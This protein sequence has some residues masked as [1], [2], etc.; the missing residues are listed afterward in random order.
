[1]NRTLILISITFATAGFS[2]ATKVKK[3]QKLVHQYESGQP[4]DFSVP[5]PPVNPFPAQFPEGNKTFVKKVE[6]NL[7]KEALASLSKNLN[8]EIIIKVNGEGDV[9]N[10][11]TYGK[12]ETLNTEV[13][14]AAIKS[15]ENIKWTA[16]KNKRGEK[17]VDIVRIPFHYKK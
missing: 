15:T 1:M 13:K 6:Q 8:T 4:Q 16:G 14:M 7:N 10:I 17:V 9:I 3:D 12:N 2:Q 5:A 11:S